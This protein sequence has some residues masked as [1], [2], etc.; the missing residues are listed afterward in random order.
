MVT[1][2][3]NIILRVVPTLSGLTNPK[4]QYEP[5]FYIVAYYV[6]TLNADR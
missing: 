5:V 4:T 2:A 3:Q 6:H 1:C